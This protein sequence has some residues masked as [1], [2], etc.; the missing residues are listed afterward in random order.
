MISFTNYEFISVF[1][2]I[3]ILSFFNCVEALIG[4]TNLFLNQ[5]YFIAETDED[6]CQ[7]DIENE[8]I[9]SEAEIMIAEKMARGK[10][11]GKEAILL[12]LKYGQS[13]LGIQEFVAKIG[14]DNDAS[15]HLFKKLQFEEHSRADV[16]E[17]I[18]YKRTVNDDWVQ[19]L[20]DE[21]QEYKVDEYLRVKKD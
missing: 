12:M 10:G 21:T 11:Y 1:F 3:V 5:D 7:D 4:D 2:F 16:F 14:Y 17:E 9:T 13:V 8:I 18:T 20:N 15:Q 19:W 6:N